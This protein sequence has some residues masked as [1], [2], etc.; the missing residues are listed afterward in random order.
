MDT[1]RFKVVT[2]TFFTGTDFENKS[3]SRDTRYLTKDELC[4]YLRAIQTDAFDFGSHGTVNVDGTPYALFE[5][6]RYQAI[7][8]CDL[9]LVRHLETCLSAPDP[10]QCTHDFSI[11]TSLPNKLMGAIHSW[12]PYRQC[13]HCK[14]LKPA[15]AFAV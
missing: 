7:P 12:T 13:R 15:S 4:E 6:S 1:E 11:V 3:A 8:R 5:R 2:R 14:H 9:C 10:S